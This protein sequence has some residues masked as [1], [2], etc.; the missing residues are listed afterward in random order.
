MEKCNRP[1]RY[2]ELKDVLDK[3]T[4]EMYE[5]YSLNTFETSNKNEKGVNC[6]GK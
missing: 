1:I 6:P 5:Q 4:F 3:K 2:Q